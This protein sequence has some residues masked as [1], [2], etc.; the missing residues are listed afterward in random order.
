MKQQKCIQSHSVNEKKE[1]ETQS[2][3]IKLKKVLKGN[4][5]AHIGSHFVCNHRYRL[6]G[7]TYTSWFPFFCI[8]HL[9]SATFENAFTFKLMLISVITQTI[10]SIWWQTNPSIEIRNGS[11]F[12]F[13]IQT[14]QID[15]LKFNIEQITNFYTIKKTVK[16]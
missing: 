1:T 14:T 5:K 10:Q 13:N 12:Q 6:V 7:F 2:K 8:F 9:C 4:C 15:P 16:I 3:N 11:T